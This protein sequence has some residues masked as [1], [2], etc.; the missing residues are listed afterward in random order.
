MGFL[1]S[2]QVLVEVSKKE[3]EEDLESAIKK[4]SPPETAKLKQEIAELE[5]LFE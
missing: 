3:M 4:W 1:N 2:R 5:Q